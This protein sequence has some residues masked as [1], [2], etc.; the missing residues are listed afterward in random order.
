MLKIIAPKIELCVI[1]HMHINIGDTEF[2]NLV[3]EWR[4][5]SSRLNLMAVNRSS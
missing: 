1:H 5:L 3:V 4:Q 2:I